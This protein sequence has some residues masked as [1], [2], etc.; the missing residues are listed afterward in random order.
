MSDT[1]QAWVRWVVA[2]VSGALERAEPKT[3]SDVDV[4]QFLRDPIDQDYRHIVTEV[5][6]NT[7]RHLREVQAI[8][9]SPAERASMEWRS[10][11]YAERSALELGDPVRDPEGAGHLEQFVR[12]IGLWYADGEPMPPLHELELWD[13][14]SDSLVHAAE[15]LH[16]EGILE[17]LIGHDVPVFLNDNLNGPE[18]LQKLNRRANPPRFY[19]RLD[20]WSLTWHAYE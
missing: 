2:G 19:E 15:I 6:W 18:D 3:R 10:D 7:E 9:A 16:G 8:A 20:R 5:S 17:R 14:H 4:I 13:A 11:A 1:A 12:S